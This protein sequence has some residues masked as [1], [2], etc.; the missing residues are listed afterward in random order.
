MKL[1][2]NE[3]TVEENGTLSEGSFGISID[4]QAH[5][6]SLLRDKI[7]SDKFKAVLREYSCNAWDAHVEAG[8]PNRPIE[9]TLP[10]TFSAELK[11]RDFGWGLTEDGIYNTFARY[12]KSTK[13]NSDDVIG[14]LGLGSKSA[15][16]YS[17]CFNIRSIQNGISSQYS[18]FIDESNKGKIVLLERK[19]TEE[20]NGL[21]IIVPVATADIK[22]FQERAL[23]VFQYFEPKPIVRGFNLNY[24]AIDRTSVICGDDWY[25]GAGAG[26]AGMTAVMGNIGYPILA[27]SLTDCPAKLKPL[28]TE[29]V[30]VNFDIG[31]LSVSVS[32]ESL[33]YTASTRQA[34]YKKL[35]D[36]HEKLTAKIDELFTSVDNPWKARNLYKDLTT[37]K[38]SYSSSYYHPAPSAKSGLIPSLVASTYK[39]MTI[40]GYK[41]NISATNVAFDPTILN[42]LG[43][44][45]DG[46]PDLVVRIIDANKKS[47][48]VSR[49]APT[50]SS[51]YT[52][53]PFNIVVVDD[54]SHYLRKF[55][56]WRLNNNS[57]TTI[58]L[59]GPA[60]TLEKSVEDFLIATGLKGKEFYR[61][62]EMSLPAPTASCISVGGVDRK[63]TA[64]KVFVLADISLSK[65]PKSDNWNDVDIDLEEDSGVYVRIKSFLPDTDNADNFAGIQRALK[66]LGHDFEN[67]PIYGFKNDIVIPLES[68]W[69]DWGLWH[70]RRLAELISTNHELIAHLNNIR[71]RKRINSIL[72]DNVSKLKID[73]DIFQKYVDAVIC[74]RDEYARLQAQINTDAEKFA[75]IPKVILD[76]IIDSYFFNEPLIFSSTVQQAIDTYE[77]YPIIRLLP[78]SA[79]LVDEALGT[80]IEYMKFIDRENSNK[81]I[82]E[83]KE[84]DEL[85]IYINE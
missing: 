17:T 46:I 14:Q 13:R 5:I 18:A 42:R 28:L 56:N 48:S 76:Q 49:W 9:V 43:Y 57:E 2:H 6:I 50:I 74:L 22:I 51:I 29:N 40:G 21:E 58:F 12:G 41:Y 31:E 63:R 54:F 7:Y 84:K 81:K 8:I 85:S 78:S 67:E 64:K 61:T 69:E 4:D 52:Y 55:S 19:K 38:S 16:C 75:T 33:E 73:N 59:S 44:P 25:I 30:V 62:S 10:T 34:I 11:I 82:E 65:H 79:F 72:K 77:L 36:I 60:D 53:T 68:E 26:W 83:D 35:K 66:K 1:K 32:R 3:I 24:P 39:N 37:V 71:L 15:F 23:S 20:E 80:V 45:S 47:F 27:A 70:R